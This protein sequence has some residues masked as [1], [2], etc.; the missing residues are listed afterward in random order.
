MRTVLVTGGGSGIGRAI[1][2]RFV[3]D[4]HAVTILGR[5]REPLE[6]TAADIGAK[7]VSCDV[8]D[9]GA[10]AAALPSLPESVDVV[11]NNAGSNT[12][13]DGPDLTPGDLHGL[14]AAWQANLRS[15]LLT[16]VLFTQAVRPRL[17]DADA[18]VV[19]IGSIAART[20]AGSYGA[21]KAAVEAWTISLAASLGGSGTANVVAPG[22]IDGT[23]YFRGRLSAPRHERLVGNT[24]VKRA[25]T[26]EDVADTVAWLSSPGAR[27]VTGQVIH[28][29][30]GAYLGR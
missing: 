23:D 4:G 9:P 12:D 14:S 19:T 5:R 11:V 13:F 16:A 24:Y 6:S 2:A 25:G 29:N 30:G 20:G 7:A 17:A 26:P 15:N 1:A 21:A 28:V 8:S 27:H 18:R 10:L 3:A 22:F